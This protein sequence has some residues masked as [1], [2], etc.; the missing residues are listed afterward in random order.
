MKY[1]SYSLFATLERYLLSHESDIANG[2][3]DFGE[4]NEIFIEIMERLPSA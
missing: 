3:N 4:L 1:M 2:I